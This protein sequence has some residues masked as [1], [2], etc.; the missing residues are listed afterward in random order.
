MKA[1]RNKLSASLASKPAQSFIAQRNQE[2]ED[3]RYM[4]AILANDPIM[5]K[6]DFAGYLF[7]RKCD[8]RPNVKWIAEARMTKRQE[9]ACERLI[10]AGA[11]VWCG[12]ELVGSGA[13]A[14]LM[15]LDLTW[16]V[17]YEDGSVNKG[18]MPM[19]RYQWPIKHPA[20]KQAAKANRS[21]VSTKLDALGGV[22]LK[23]YSA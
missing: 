14:I 4:T 6:Q 11:T 22:T 3:F 13:T 23:R 7:I 21:Q 17:L 5:R 19:L 8:K 20:S 15:K 10:E 1:W 9:Q 18:D 16:I 2:E 12:V